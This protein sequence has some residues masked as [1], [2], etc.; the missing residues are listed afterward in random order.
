V[1]PRRIRVVQAAVI[2]AVASVLV[3]S[4]WW[5]RPSRTVPPPVSSPSPAAPELN[6][7]QFGKII[8]GDLVM[9]A[10]VVRK[11]PHAYPV[12]KLSPAN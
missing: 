10:E 6:G 8:P 12:T 9:R 4:I 11:R 3:L 7:S 1:I 2:L 5:M